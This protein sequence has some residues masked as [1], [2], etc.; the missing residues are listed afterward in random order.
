MYHCAL[1]LVDTDRTEPVTR[2]SLLSA[3]RAAPGIC[4]VQPAAWPAKCFG[5]TELKRKTQ[6]VMFLNGHKL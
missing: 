4:V 1:P 6:K 5:R 2:E 3:G